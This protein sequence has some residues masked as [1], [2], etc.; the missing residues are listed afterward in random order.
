MDIKKMI[1]KPMMKMA[2]ESYRQGKSDFEKG[3]YNEDQFTEQMDQLINSQ[4]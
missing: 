3:E 1:L 4:F 2:I